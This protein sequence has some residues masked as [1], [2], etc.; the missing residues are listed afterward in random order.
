MG[1]VN[2]SF[3]G[4]GLCKKHEIT[5]SPNRPTMTVEQQVGD[6]PTVC[7]GFQPNE[8]ELTIARGEAVNLSFKGFAKKTEVNESPST[9]V[10]STKRLLHHADNID[11]KVD[12]VAFA[13]IT[14]FKLNYKNNVIPE[15][16]LTHGS[17][18]AFRGLGKTEYEGEIE[19]IIDS[20]NAIP[21]YQK[22]LNNTMRGMQISIMG[23]EIASDPGNYEGLIIDLAKVN[24][25][26]MEV[27]ATFETV[28]AKIKFVGLLD[29][30]TGGHLKFTV[31]N[32]L[33]NLA[34]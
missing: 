14:S 29:K 6:L 20:V 16:D 32:D 24:F 4:G 28:K 17:E 3:I 21:E 30:T 2:T 11:V 10:A 22:Y 34:S 1:K 25:K 15:H 5:E 23:D 9:P 12:G 8:M 26:E 31:L 27:P 19:L 13:G 7:T 18:V 33:E